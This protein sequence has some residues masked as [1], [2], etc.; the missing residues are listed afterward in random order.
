MNLSM[1]DSDFGPIIVNMYGGVQERGPTVSVHSHPGNTVEIL[2]W[3]ELH[4]S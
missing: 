4:V 3:S 1:K 2:S